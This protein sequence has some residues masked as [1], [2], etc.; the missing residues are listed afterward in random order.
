MDCRLG[1]G[2][3]R[4]GRS[5]IRL[6]GLRELR[7][8][9]AMLHRVPQGLDPAPPGPVQAVGDGVV[10]AHTVDAFRLDRAVS[11]LYADLRV[12]PVLD[13]LLEHSRALLGTVAGSISLVDTA[14]GRYD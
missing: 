6:P 13:R 14:Q 11:D 8:V 5:R 10:A 3:S 2:G 9:E 1:D 7:R 12:G 4:T